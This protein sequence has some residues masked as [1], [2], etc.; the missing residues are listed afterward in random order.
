MSR[1]V[2]IADHRHTGCATILRKCI[3]PSELVSES[4]D[5]NRLANLEVPKQVCDDNLTLPDSR[6]LSGACITLL[7]YLFQYEENL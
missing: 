2:L 6:G 4:N 5:F 7:G 1:Y 3:L